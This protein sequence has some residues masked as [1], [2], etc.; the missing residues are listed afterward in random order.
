MAI[1]DFTKSKSQEQVEDKEVQALRSECKEL[2]L[3]LP[4]ERGWRT[5]YLYKF[6]G[7]WCQPKEIQAVL[8]VQQHFQARDSDILLAT[9]PKSGTTWLK[10]L[11]FA[12]VNREKFG[13]SKPH[14]PLLSSNSH[15]LVPFLEYKLYTNNQIPDLSGIPEPRVFATH[16]P[17]PWLPQSAK[18]SNCKIVYLCRNPLDTFISS[19]HFVQKLRP[20]SLGPFSIEDAFDMF[21]KG[22][23]GFGPIWENILW[24]WRESLRN[25]Q[26]IMFLKYE[27]MKEDITFHLKKLAKFL[28]FPFSL[29]EEKRGVIEGIAKLCSFETMKDIDANKKGKSILNIDNKNLFRKAEVGDWVNYLTPSMVQK[30][31][32]VLDEKLGGSGLAF[33]FA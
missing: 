29:E 20:E 31:S 32:K 17:F 7:F 24:Y 18:K 12:I 30:F 13:V 22:A 27:D 1:T 15:D 23:I 2:F 14:H 26:K 5:P 8:S 19:W 16:M 28:D 21:C 3:S 9:V 11:V 10:A 33:K 25:P 6:Q 4:R